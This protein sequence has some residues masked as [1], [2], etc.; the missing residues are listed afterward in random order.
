[1]AQVDW[2]PH[3]TTGHKHSQQVGGGIPRKQNMG[4]IWS[5]GTALKKY[6]IGTLNMTCMDKYTQTLESTLS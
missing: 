2:V 5:L 3:Y 4:P 1:M 6:L